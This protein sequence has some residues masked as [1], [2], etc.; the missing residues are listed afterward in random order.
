MRNIQSA[1]SDDAQIACWQGRR[2][3]G[4]LRD[5]HSRL[6]RRGRSTRHR[7]RRARGQSQR[8]QCKRLLNTATRNK[9][10]IPSK[11][12]SSQVIGDLPASRSLLKTDFMDLTMLSYSS[13]YCIVVIHNGNC[14]LS[15][16]DIPVSHSQPTQTFTLRQKSLRNFCVLSENVISLDLEFNQFQIF[17]QNGFA[18]PFKFF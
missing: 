16:H 10:C 7:S 1:G 5:G 15:T 8:L 6:C 18:D 9:L 12:G 14:N 3:G 17:Q 11:S 2:C 13:R 4:A